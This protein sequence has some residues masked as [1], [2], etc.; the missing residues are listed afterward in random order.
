MIFREVG[1]QYRFAEQEFFDSHDRLTMRAI[2]KL[3]S[4]AMRL[5][6][7]FRSRIVY[8]RKPDSPR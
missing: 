8:L 1:F 5:Y 3:G 6:R 4:P 2:G 7:T